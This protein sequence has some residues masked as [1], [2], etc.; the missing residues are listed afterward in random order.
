MPSGA[1]GNTACTI[2]PKSGHNIL[3]VGH[4]QKLGHLSQFHAYW[5]CGNSSKLVPAVNRSLWGPGDCDFR[6]FRC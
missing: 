5:V 3:Q 1:R 4:L 6:S 2:A